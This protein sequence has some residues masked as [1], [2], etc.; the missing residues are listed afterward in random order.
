MEASR[1][2]V[3][4]PTQLR[5]PLL[6][7]GAAA[8]SWLLP[9]AGLGLLGLSDKGRALL[10]FSDGVL[11]A[12]A[13]AAA[14]AGL[15]AAGV[16][17][18]GGLPR[19]P[20]VARRRV[21]LG[22]SASVAVLVVIA[23]G[24]AFGAAAR[25]VDI[26]QETAVSLR[27]YA[28]WNGAGG[29]GGTMVFASEVDP[30]SSF[31]RRLVR[32]YDSAFRPVLFSIDNRAGARDVA[33]DVVGARL[34]APGGRSVSAVAPADLATHLVDLSAALTLGRRSTV[35]VPRGQRVDGVQALFPAEASL[36][37]VQAIE[38]R[39]DGV[40]HALP[41]RY[42]TLDDKRAIDARRSAAPAP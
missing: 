30:A 35:T 20:G 31:G 41:G 29:A 33:L 7:A 38:V 19:A 23:A 4:S 13:A 5:P 1:T 6:S 18:L 28:G 9:L 2:D 12:V 16:A 3:V 26:D 15:I 36:R 34:L 32:P 10:P 25:A 8:A 40:P 39:L 22:A 27:D 14:L 42:F 21:L 11:I 37:D 17:L 24:I